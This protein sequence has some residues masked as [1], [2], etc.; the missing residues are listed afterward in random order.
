MAINFPK[1]P[2]NGTKYTYASVEYT[3][4]KSAQWDDGY[5]AVQTPASNGAATASEINAGTN[6]N[7]YITPL[8]LA[9]SK[10]T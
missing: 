9:Q 7:K 3:Y 6:N 5:W 2:I 1:T 10:Y 4:L 8:G